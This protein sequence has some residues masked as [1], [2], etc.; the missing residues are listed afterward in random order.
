MRLCLALAL[1][2]IG[3]LPVV[4]APED[5]W[6]RNGL[7][8]SEQ[9][10]LG[11]ARAMAAPRTWFLNDGD[12]ETG[13]PQKGAPCR[14]G[15]VVPGQ[16]VLTGKTRGGFVCAF[17]PNKVGGTAGWVPS[18]QLQ[19]IPVMAA[20]LSDWAGKWADGDDDITIAVKG[21]SLDASGTAIWHGLNNDI[22]DGEFSAVAGPRGN[23]VTFSQGPHQYDCQ[24][25]AVLVGSYL[26]VSDNRNC[27]GVNVNFD[28]V[29]RKK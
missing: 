6:C 14:H 16:I 2:L 1:F 23:H 9:S 13:C 11:L 15:Y 5:A 24:V 17:F 28:G 21:K 26:V 18:S 10:Q 8:P 12:T 20:S 27:G 4:A 7:F 29:Y 19:S 22:H 25:H 3:T